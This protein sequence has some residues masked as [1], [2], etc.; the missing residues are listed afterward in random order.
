MRMMMQHEMRKAGGDGGGIKGWINR[1]RRNLKV[2]HVGGKR[3]VSVVGVY[4]KPACWSHVLERP[5][6]LPD[7][8]CALPSCSMGWGLVA[9]G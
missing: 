2:R 4:T 1:Q 6:I 5:S 9:S 8:C 3:V 7:C